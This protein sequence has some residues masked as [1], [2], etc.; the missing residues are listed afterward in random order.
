MNRPPLREVDGDAIPAADAL[1]SAAVAASAP[2]MPAISPS[3]PDRF[4]NREL[5]WLA[6]DRRVLEEAFDPTQLTLGERQSGRHL[7]GMLLVVPQVGLGD[8]DLEFS[9][10]G[11]GWTPVYQQ[12]ITVKNSVTQPTSTSPDPVQTYRTADESDGLYDTPI[13]R[14]GV[15]KVIIS[16][17]GQWQRVLGV[18]DNGTAV[19]QI[20]PYP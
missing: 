3:S 6:F 1:P 12:S 7:L 8:F 20:L 19:D 16:S 10:S 4:I 5:S 13:M 17:N 15:F 2:P 11:G 14:Q 9:Q 18:D